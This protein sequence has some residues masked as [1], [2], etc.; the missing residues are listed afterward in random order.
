MQLGGGGP[1]GQ[2]EKEP[3]LGVPPAAQHPT[4][5]SVQGWWPDPQAV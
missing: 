1:E 2:G 3:W 4:T 5:L